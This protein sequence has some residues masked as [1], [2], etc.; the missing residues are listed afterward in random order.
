MDIQSMKHASPMKLLKIMLASVQKYSSTPLKT[1]YKVHL[2]VY[3]PTI[4]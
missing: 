2:M 4:K 3:I 1:V